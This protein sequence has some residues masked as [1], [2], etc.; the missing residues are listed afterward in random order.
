MFATPFVTFFLILIPWAPEITPAILKLS[1]IRPFLGLF[2]V[3]PSCS[4]SAF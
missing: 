1:W 4:Y 3:A 2:P